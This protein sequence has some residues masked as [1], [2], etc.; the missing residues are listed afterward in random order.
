[1]LPTRKKRG[2]WRLKITIKI[3]WQHGAVREF[4]DS[5]AIFSA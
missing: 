4:L 5:N 3:I 1:M 2:V